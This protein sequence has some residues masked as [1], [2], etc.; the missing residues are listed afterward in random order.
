MTPPSIHDRYIEDPAESP[1][2]KERAEH[3]WMVIKDRATGRAYIVCMLTR[4]N[5][6]YLLQLM[7]AADRTLDRLPVEDAA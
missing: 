6:L 7:N 2:E 5:A 1:A 3:G 4:A